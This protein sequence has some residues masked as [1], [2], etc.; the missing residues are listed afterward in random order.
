MFDFFVTQSLSSDFP[1][2][3]APIGAATLVC[4]QLF[5]S[6]GLRNQQAL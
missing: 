5:T 3:M 4:F 2:K 6:I 1:M